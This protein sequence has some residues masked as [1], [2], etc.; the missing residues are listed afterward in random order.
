MKKTLIVFL[1]LTLTNCSPKLRSTI[2]KTLPPLSNNQLVVVLSI[3][4]QE[5]IL[6]GKIGELKATDSGFSENCTYYENIQNLKILARKA[7]AN[8]IKI[9]KYNPANKLSSCERVWA[10]IY[11]VD[12]PKIY[13][14]EIEWSENRKLTWDDF[15]GVPETETF[16]QALAVTN[17]GIGYQS[18][19]NLFRNGKVFVQTIF[20][21][22][23]SWFLP[24]GKNDY[25]L[26][27]EQIHFDI[28]E[29]Y[30]RMLRKALADAN[31]T[32]NNFGKAQQIFNDIV[33]K[34]K[35]RQEYYDYNTKF[36][37]REDTQQKWQAIIE[38]ELAKYNLYK[39]N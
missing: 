12:N 15:K 26:R 34:W 13:E 35:E 32:S 16:P 3:T 39:S 5:Q 17:S 7:G 30:S 22:N 4:D 19:I 14:E 18:G 28:T 23:R 38:I 8:L 6:T 37:K 25:V 33:I 1:F 29:I 10:D 31:V 36:S 9:T 2:L 21:T 11:K 20:Y 27:H 24:E